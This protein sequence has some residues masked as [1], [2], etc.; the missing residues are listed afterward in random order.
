VSAL[1]QHDERV[2]CLS[3]RFSYPAVR[4][5]CPMCGASAPEDA[6]LGPRPVADKAAAT[7]VGRQRASR[8]HLVRTPLSLAVAV[9]VAACG[10]FF[11]RARSGNAPDII[12]PAPAIAATPPGPV[13]PKATVSET[14]AVRPQLV[15][16]E[17]PVPAVPAVAPVSTTDDPAELWKRVGNGNTDAEVTLA[18]FYLDGHR[19]TQN[20]EQAHLLLLAAAKKRNRAADQVLSNLYPQRCP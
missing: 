14:V 13:P 20:C 4:G 10:L 9:L 16:Q 3:C 8:R 12:A 17:P 2:T 15:S 18:R 6:V 5:Y 1:P 11:L 19:V 7:Q